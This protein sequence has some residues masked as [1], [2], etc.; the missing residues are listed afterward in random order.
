MTE[1]TRRYTLL[2]TLRDIWASG[3]DAILCAA[4][5]Q[6]CSDQRG[7]VAVTAS[8]SLVGCVSEGHSANQNARNE[9]SQAVENAG[10]CTTQ[11]DAVCSNS[12][13][14]STNHGDNESDG[15]RNSE[16]NTT[17]NHLLEKN[18]HHDQGYQPPVPLV[19]TVQTRSNDSYKVLGYL[20]KCERVEDLKELTRLL[21]VSLERSPEEA[22]LCHSYTKVL[23]KRNL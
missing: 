21:L 9:G 13:G 14:S 23:S 12:S 5:D 6:H 22:G 15:T 7:T 3:R 19:D 16:L 10:T 4:Q 17:E 2:Q 18:D 1:F 8:Q 11:S 20:V